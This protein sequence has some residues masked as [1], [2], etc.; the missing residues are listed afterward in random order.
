MVPVRRAT[1]GDW[2]QGGYN[3]REAGTHPV[4]K[5]RRRHSS[6]CRTGA[7]ASLIAQGAE[8]AAVEHCS[9]FSEFVVVVAVF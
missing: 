7:W 5:I 1:P 3:A 9:N 8:V 6:T 4:P 2:R